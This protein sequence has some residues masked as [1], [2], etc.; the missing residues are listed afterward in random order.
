M[1]SATS[2]PHPH[3]FACNFRPRPCQTG[4]TIILPESEGHAEEVAP[5]PDCPSL[6][7]VSAGATSP[8]SAPD[9]PHSA[10]WTA[11]MLP[12]FRA[13]SHLSLISC[14][15]A[16][17]AQFLT[18]SWLPAQTS[19]GPVVLSF[20]EAVLCWSTWF[21]P[22]DLLATWPIGIHLPVCGDVVSEIMLGASD[23]NSQAF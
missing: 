5:K 2:D 6:D 7:A 13:G 19:G 23:S 1:S 18:M 20:P 22:R 11:K 12:I 3:V 9:V 8:W 21:S 16:I 17:L 4:Q 10:A 15:S 14:T